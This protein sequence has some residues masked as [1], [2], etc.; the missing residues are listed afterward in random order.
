M[1][2]AIPTA[3]AMAD[4]QHGIH[5]EYLKSRYHKILLDVM[6]RIDK[7]INVQEIY[8]IHSMTME[9]ALDCTKDVDHNDF[10]GF[11]LLLDYLGYR[12]NHTRESIKGLIHT[13]YLL[14]Q[15]CRIVN[16]EIFW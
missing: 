8:T 2:L 1:E 10:W 6:G 4:K 11:V 5:L 12:T 7:K 14:N 9:Y 16:L 3:R 15:Q 13:G